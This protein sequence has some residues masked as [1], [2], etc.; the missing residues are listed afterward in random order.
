MIRNAHRSMGLPLVGGLI[1]LSAL[2][3]AAVPTDV[4]AASG[5]GR[6]EIGARWFRAMLAADTD[7]ERKTEADGTLSLLIVHAG[8]ADRA[9][10]LVDA[11]ANPD[12][13]RVPEPIRGLPVRVEVVR[14]DEIPSLGSRVV[15]GFFLGE[16]LRRS[17]LDALIRSGATRQALVYSPFDG[18]V[19]KGVPGGLSIQAQV[20][21]LIN[22]PSLRASQITLRPSFL[23]V[24][25]VYP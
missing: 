10:G 16:S 20:R 23:R 12:A 8:D 14:I 6:A 25:K 18:D 22:P 4:Q 17:H 1:F 11:V 21:P 19:E 24:A 2:L 15:A 3:G 5:D 13:Q 7:I 9:R